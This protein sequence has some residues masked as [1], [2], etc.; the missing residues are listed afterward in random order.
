MQVP[1]TSSKKYSHKYMYIDTSL[2][3]CCIQNILQAEYVQIDK[4]TQVNNTTWD[5]R[6]RRQQ[7]TLIQVR[8]TWMDSAQWMI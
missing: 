5:R 1:C 6:A 4:H 8:V 7:L 2:L 3:A